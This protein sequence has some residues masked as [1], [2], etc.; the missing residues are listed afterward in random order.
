MFAE[1]YYI[2]DICCSVEPSRKNSSSTLHLV[3]VEA[4]TNAATRKTSTVHCIDSREL[5]RKMNCLLLKMMTRGDRNVIDLG[6]I[7]F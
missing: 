5:T 4:K 3:G 7:K 1:V 2:P 6:T